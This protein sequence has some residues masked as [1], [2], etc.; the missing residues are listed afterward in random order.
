M[1][2][3]KDSVTKA[4]DGLAERLFEKATAAC[5]RLGKD[6]AESLHDFR[7]ALRRLRT[8]LE[9][10]KEY[11]GRRRANKMRKSLSK[12][13]SATNTTRDFEVQR[14]WIEQQVS[15]EG[16]SEIQREGLQ[17]ILVEFYGNGQNGTSRA[18]LE[19]V[20]SRFAKIGDK[21]TRPRWSIPESSDPNAGIVAVTRAALRK[22]AAKLRDQLGQI[23]SVDSV[24]ATHRARLALKRLRYILEPMAKIIPDAHDLVREFKAMQ[25]TLG[26]LRDLQILRMQISLAA[27]AADQIE[28]WAAEDPAAAELATAVPSVRALE[29]HKDALEA[30]LDHVRT[31]AERH[32]AVLSAIVLSLTSAAPP[33][34]PARSADRCGLSGVTPI[35]T[36]LPRERVVEFSI[37]DILETL[38]RVRVGY[39]RD[40]LHTAPE[41]AR[42]P[43]GRP[44]VEL[45]FSRVLEVIDTGVF[46][47]TPEGLQPWP[48]RRCT[49]ITRGTAE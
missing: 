32:F 18:E 33:N 31:E 28:A 17:L 6:D 15:D 14:A 27:G 1:G 36:H 47:K 4:H 37:E 42:T 30:G 38:T 8:H 5:A 23:E 25:D 2:H 9:T 10:H 7:V 46:E 21:F 34:T 45:G 26:S 44:D 29:E 39:R 19:P 41:I 20:K 3:T 22:H 43:V 24:R 11:L 13:V 49:L 35:G 40:H 12:L 16:V 48:N